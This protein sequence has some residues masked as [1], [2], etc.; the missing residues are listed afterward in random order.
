MPKAKYCPGKPSQPTSDPT[1]A[2]KQVLPSLASDCFSKTLDFIG[3]NAR[4]IQSSGKPIQVSPDRDY[5]FD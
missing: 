1:A 5:F 4:K 2:S 3:Q